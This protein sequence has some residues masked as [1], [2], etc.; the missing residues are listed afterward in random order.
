MSVTDQRQSAYIREDK[1]KS[2]SGVDKP[3]LLH[4]RR[5]SSTISLLAQFE[6]DIEPLLPPESKQAVDDFKRSCRKKLNGLTFLAIELMKL[7][8]GERVNEH[9]VDLAE[10]T[11]NA[12]ED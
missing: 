12:T 7:R 8:R 10:E 9:A 2:G 3:A 11:F 1:S 4:L 5:K 6:R